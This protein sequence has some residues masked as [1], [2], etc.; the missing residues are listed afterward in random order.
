MYETIDTNIFFHAEVAIVITV[1]SPQSAA[2][3]YQKW[4]TRWNLLS[5]YIQG[6]TGEDQSCKASCTD[7]KNEAW[8]SL[9]FYSESDDLRRKTPLSVNCKRSIGDDDGCLYG[10]HFIWQGIY[11]HVTGE[12]LG[13]HAVAIVR[14]N[15]IERYIDTGT[16]GGEG[17]GAKMVCENLLWWWFWNRWRNLGIYSLPGFCRWSFIDHQRMIMITS[18]SVSGSF[19]VTFEAADR[20]VGQHYDIIKIVS[21]N[22]LLT[23]NRMQRSVQY[24]YIVSDGRYEFESTTQWKGAV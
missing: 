23:K 19:E 8:K 14:Y 15:D 11:R 17:T 10:F 7:S 12:M 22:F 4:V 1:G 24:C 13:G 6:S 16:V 5:L 21:R 18:W 9:L 3:Y 2:Q 20:L